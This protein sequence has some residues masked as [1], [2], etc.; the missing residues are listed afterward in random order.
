MAAAIEIC[1]ELCPR[2]SLDLV[3]VVGESRMMDNDSQPMQDTLT[4]PES[5]FSHSVRP[6]GHPP[7]CRQTVRSILLSATHSH[8]LCAICSLVCAIPVVQSC[9]SVSLFTFLN[10]YTAYNMPTY[11][12]FVSCS[13]YYVINFF[14]PISFLKKY[15]DNLI[16]STMSGHT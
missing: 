15:V 2:M 4:A 16:S 1:V 9:K 13:I 10:L 3:E 5:S 12:Y 7:C 14:S 8:I 11:S 6:Q